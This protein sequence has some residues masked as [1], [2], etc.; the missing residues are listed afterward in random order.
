MSSRDGVIPLTLAT[1]ALAI[2]VAA[3]LRVESLRPP[4]DL[5]TLEMDAAKFLQIT[6]RDEV[7]VTVG[8]IRVDKSGPPNTRWLALEYVEHEN[9]KG[10]V[11]SQEM[12]FTNLYLV[13]QV[14]RLGE[15]RAAIKERYLVINLWH[16]YPSSSVKT[17]HVWTIWDGELNP[18]RSRAA[19]RLLVEDFNNAFLGE[20]Q[21]RLDD[22]TIDRLT[23]F[24]GR[25]RAFLLKGARSFPLAHQS[26]E[27][28][29][30]ALTGR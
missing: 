2:C 16:Y 13:S 20:R 7:V 24:Y 3:C 25:A 12:E 21:A 11:P 9:Q 26:P 15:G 1:V 14:E 8:G 5:S 18:A 17:C 23:E 19:F 28:E 4:L 30:I 29:A 10:F 22:L 27:R 6:F